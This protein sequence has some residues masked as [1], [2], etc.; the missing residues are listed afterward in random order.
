MYHHELDFFILKGIFNFIKK[1]LGRNSAVMLRENIL[2]NKEV[3]QFPYATFYYLAVWLDSLVTYLFFKFV[4]GIVL[5]DRWLYD[6]TTVFAHTGYHSTFM[7]KLF[8]SFP[9]PDIMIVLTVLPEI[10]HQRKRGDVAHISH[11][12]AYYQIM[13]RR[14]LELATKLGK[15]TVI[16]ANRSVDEVVDT[17]LSLIF[18]K[19]TD[20]YK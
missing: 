14:I 12:L 6:I 17:I 5:C 4:S 16:D 10:A 11:D 18:K 13:D 1:V 19:I 2:T 9:R 15:N 8:L 7:R 20:K 3:G